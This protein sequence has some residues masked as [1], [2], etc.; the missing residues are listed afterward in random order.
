V[1]LN[2]NACI[3]K[4]EIQLKVIQKQEHP[5]KSSSDVL[6]YRMILS[7]SALFFYSL[8]CDYGMFAGFWIGLP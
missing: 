6:I 2:T 3:Q 1:I 8:L 4:K 5:K 7:Y